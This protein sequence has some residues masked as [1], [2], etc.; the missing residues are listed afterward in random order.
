M[1]ADLAL[2]ARR[3]ITPEEISLVRRTTPK[4]TVEALAVD[5]FSMASGPTGRSRLVKVVA[6]DPGFPFYGKFDLQFGQD[7]PQKEIDNLHQIQSAWMYPEA[8][9]QLGI[10][11]GES[12]KLGNLKFQLANFV[13]EESGLSF[14]PTDLAPK[15]FISRNFLEQTG[16]M[17]QGNLAFH[18]LLLRLPDGTDTETFGEALERAIKSPEVRVYSHQKTG[19]R[20]GRLLRYLSDFLSLV[21]LVSLFLA[22]LGSGFLFHGFLVN[23]LPELAVLI[24]LGTPRSTVLTIFSFLLAI[25]GILAALPACLAC[26]AFLP[27]L[28]LLIEG[29]GTK[30]LHLLISTKS[31][32]LT[33]GV[34]IASGW[35]LSLPALNKIRRLQPIDLFREAARPG[36]IAKRFNLFASLPGL[37]AFWILCLTQANS[38]KLANVFF[39][40]FLGSLIVLYFLSRFGFL[41][42]E[43]LLVRTALPPRLAA[44]SLSRNRAGA[45]TGFLALSLG[46]LLLTLIP[47]TQHGL[48]KE[49]GLDNAEGELPSLFLF[50]LQEEQLEEVQSFLASH[51]SPLNNLTPWVRGKIRTIKGLPYE[52]SIGEEKEINNPDEQRLMPFA[53]AASI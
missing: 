31:I 42:L 21:S 35:L 12:L 40:C 19:H 16:L 18:T 27:A 48:S 8:K 9:A 30:G 29:I 47:Q 51:N 20:A 44:R 24:C 53:T 13:E 11:R 41:L 6:M 52:K 23:R 37:L 7:L 33:F 4:D 2:R 3:P 15:V 17:G 34:A 46:V 38:D 49:I 36:A 50:D 28:S 26:I 25:L 5:F 1:G 39:L 43:R 32:I 22:C 14:Q 10:D 45:V